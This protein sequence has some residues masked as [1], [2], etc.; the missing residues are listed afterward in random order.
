VAYSIL[1]ELVAADTV[2]ILLQLQ[3]AKMHR[4]EWE[5][6]RYILERNEKAR[7][8]IRCLAMALEGRKLGG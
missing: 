4:K 7:A 6:I 5:L 8:D 1:G 3:G 2:Q